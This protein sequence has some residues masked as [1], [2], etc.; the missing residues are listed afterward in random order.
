LLLATFII[1]LARR[2]L[3]VAAIHLQSLTKKNARSPVIRIRSK[4]S[5]T[6]LFIIIRLS[7]IGYRSVLFLLSAAQHG[8]SAT[9]LQ[10]LPRFSGS[11]DIV[12][13]HTLVI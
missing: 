8:S 6:L 12:Q 1:S 9:A 7:V 3:L 5:K 11:E 13:M 2:Q 4:Q 10:H